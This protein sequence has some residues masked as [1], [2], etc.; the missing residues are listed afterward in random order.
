MRRSTFAIPAL[1]GVATLVGLIVALTG[2][3][4]RDA[5][6]WLALAVPVATALWAIRN[7]Q[8]EGSE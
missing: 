2:D 4:W 8:T 7:K 6:A 5:V 1:I 3:G